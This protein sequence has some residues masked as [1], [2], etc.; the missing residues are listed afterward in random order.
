MLFRSKRR[1][2]KSQNDMTGREVT[3]AQMLVTNS[4][5]LEATAQSHLALSLAFRLG[6]TSRLETLC[7]AQ[8]QMFNLAAPKQQA[9][10]ETGAILLSEQCAVVLEQRLI[11][12]SFM[13]L[14]ESRLEL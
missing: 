9:L 7:L 12:Y 6:E 1:E 10:Q 2:M 14:A 5:M 13:E 8:K 11:T 4:A 3:S